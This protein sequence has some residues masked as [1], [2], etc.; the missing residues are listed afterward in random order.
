MQRDDVRFAVAAREDGLHRVRSLTTRIGVASLACSA[1]IA[2]ALG[3]PAGAAVHSTTGDGSAS[4]NQTGHNGTSPGTSTPQG[5]SAQSNSPG[6]SQQ[7][8]SPQGSSSQQG[9][10]QQGSSP[11]APAQNLA[12]A[13]GPGQVVSGGS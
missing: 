6:T 11:Q 9:S 12:P 7:G 10:S 1:V 8:T 3:H 13:A 4:N 2:V 5:K